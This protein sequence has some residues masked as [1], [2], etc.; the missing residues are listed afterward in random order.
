MKAQDENKISP[1]S[2][3][4]FASLL[5]AASVGVPKAFALTDEEEFLKL[6]AEAQRIQS[7]IDVGCL[8]IASSQRTAFVL[9]VERWFA[10]KRKLSVVSWRAANQSR[11]SRRN[12]LLPARTRT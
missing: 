6:Q 5:F 10:A 2:R 12:V 7:V 3:R 8:P 1:V 9:I 11:P 4:L